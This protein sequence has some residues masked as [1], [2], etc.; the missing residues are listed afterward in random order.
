MRNAIHR[1]LTDL[2]VAAGLFLLVALTFCPMLF[3]QSSEPTSTISTKVNEVSIDLVVR[4]G[5]NPVL[6][7]T[8]QDFVVSDAG[9][10][11]KVSSFRLVDQNSASS[12]FTLVFD[13]LDS[14]AAANA[15]KIVSE[16]LKQI[17]ES[18]FVLSVLSVQ[19]QLQLRQGFTSDRSLINQAV[20]DATQDSLK[21]ETKEGV[22]GK[23]LVTAAKRGRDASGKTMT[24][25]QRLQAQV[26][27]AAL[28]D[29]QHIEREAHPKPALAGLLAVVR[30]QRKLPGLKIVFFITPNP[31]SASQD[32]GM[33]AQIVSAAN[34]SAVHIVTIDANTRNDEAGQYMEAFNQ[35]KSVMAMK[36]NTGV[37][38]TQT[39]S[40]GSQTQPPPGPANVQ[41]P[42][43]PMGAMGTTI[44]PTLALDKA[45]YESLDMPGSRPSSPIC[46][47]AEQSGGFCI[48]MGQNPK[49]PIRGLVQDM[50]SY[51]EASFVPAVKEYDGKFHAI[52]VK[53]VRPGLK[54]K[55]RSGYFALPPEPEFAIEAF[56]Q[57]LLTMLTQPTLP[58]D[59]QF[60][61]RSLQL[62]ES[63]DGNTNAVVVQVPL[64]QL[65]THDD[66][67]TNLYSTHVSVLAQI[68]DNSGQVIQH[69]A[70]DIPQHGALDRKERGVADNLRL[71]WQFV[72]DPGEYVLEVAVLDRNSGKASALRSTFQVA[73]GSRVPFLS[74]LSL[75]AHTEPLPPGGDSDDILRYADARVVPE[76]SR[77]VPKGQKDIFIFSTV[78]ADARSNERPQLQLILSRNGQPMAQAPLLL[79][80]AQTEDAIPYVASIHTA[81]LPAGSYQVTE[82][83]TQG[84]AVTE[85]NVAFEIPGPEFATSLAPSNVA[86]P[87]SSSMVSDQNLGVADAALALTRSASLAI[88]ELPPGS[89]NKPSPE[90]FQALVS[91]ATTYALRYSKSLPNFVCM[92]TTQRSIDKDGHGDWKL[93]DSYAELLRYDGHGES[94]TLL[95]SKEQRGMGENGPDT[96]LPFSTGE[97]G[98]LLNLVFQPGSKTSF[99]WQGVARLGSES[100]QVLRYVVSP[101]NATMGLR[102]SRSRVFNVGVHGLVYVDPTTGGVRRITLEAD[103][104]PPQCLFHFVTMMVD[105]EFVTIGAHDY[106]LPMRAALSL[107]RGNKRTEL[108][109]IAFRD[110]RRFAS[111]V[112]ILPMK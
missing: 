1:L 58:H 36:D 16:V 17:P 32:G 22:S 88:T 105:Y 71:H 26:L 76:L 97:L 54:L 2:A 98:G 24:A 34:R 38:M 3:S 95:T 108:N 56:E 51:Y 48:R 4:S 8:P 6:D 111:Q 33:M 50:A 70:Q 72:A 100:A 77:E 75:V 23:D 83:L 28:Q 78:H 46:K 31:S 103:N 85:K 39:Q 89:A 21:M 87:P 35:M 5:K 49:D 112:K 11:V 92:E 86:T 53:A 62:G 81:S 7:L 52:K 73:D 91:A 12:L 41:S 69:F 107:R 110:Y 104:I 43:A 13:K 64:A 63:E 99:E 29:A 42:Q 25:E 66:P 65:E 82:R 59:L 9:T 61:A 47:L 67:N 19:G 94:R 30:S 96:S 45:H 55:T 80:T 10:P 93:Q 27:L 20:V 60:E 40:T 15:R 102:E 74:D 90:A 44:T 101:K 109:E 37:V 68:K 57:P 14:A 18:G 106:L 84:Q 79:K